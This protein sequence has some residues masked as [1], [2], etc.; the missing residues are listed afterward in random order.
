MWAATISR[1]SDG[2]D[3]MARATVWA[4]IFWASADRNHWLR[5]CAASDSRR[6]RRRAAR[7]AMSA[8]LRVVRNS[9]ATGSLGARDCSASFI[10]ACWTAASGSSHSCRAYSTSAG[11]CASKSRPINAGSTMSRACLP[12]GSTTY[13]MPPLWRHPHSHDGRRVGVAAAGDH[14]AAGGVP[15]P[16]RCRTH[17]PSNT[18]PATAISASG[19]IHP[20]Q[21][22]AAPSMKPGVLPPASSGVTSRP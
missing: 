4:S 8:S 1:W 13:K 17:R 10:N 22:V 3:A 20:L 5:F 15:C 12:L 21:A 9:H 6:R 7:Q 16:T 11:A 2:S 19:I 18:P 14:V